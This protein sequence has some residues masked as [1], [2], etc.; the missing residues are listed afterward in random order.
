MKIYITIIYLVAFAGF[1]SAQQKKNIIN[2]DVLV[3]QL[4]VNQDQAILIQEAMKYNIEKINS[5]AMDKRIDPRKK[6]DSLKGLIKEH[7]NKLKIL[8]SP[9]QIAKLENYMRTNN[10]LSEDD[11]R[12]RVHNESSRNK[13]DKVRRQPSTI[14]PDKSK[15]DIKDSKGKN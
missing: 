6:I 10:M 4:G 1:A 7:D 8:L 3:V 2:T 15:I 9:Q 13:Q 11:K 5:L 14:V 12:V